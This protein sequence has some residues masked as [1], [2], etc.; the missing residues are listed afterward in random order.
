MID[1]STRK[2]IRERRL[3]WFDSLYSTLKQDKGKEMLR[4]LAK[5]ASPQAGLPRQY[6]IDIDLAQLAYC[7]LRV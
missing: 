5:A 1:S 2:K 4:L 6:L 7:N 3:I